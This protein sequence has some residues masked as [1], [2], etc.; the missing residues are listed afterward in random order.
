[1]KAQRQD[2]G[3]IALTV[4]SMKF[5][6]ESTLSKFIVESYHLTKY[7]DNTIHLKLELHRLSGPFWMSLFIP[8]ICLVLAAEVALF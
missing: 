6:A 5:E 4:H 8:S 2:E 3:Q 1:M 7:D